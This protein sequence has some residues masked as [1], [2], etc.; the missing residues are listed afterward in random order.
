MRLLRLPELAPDEEPKEDKREPEASVV[1]EPIA[2]LVFDDD[3]PGRNEV[4]QGD[5]AG[6]EGDVGELLVRYVLAL[7]VA[8]A[9][10]AEQDGLGPVR[11]SQTRAE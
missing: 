11:R 10:P 8:K 7:D 2:M 1:K 6:G 3:L 9:R 4:A 5:D